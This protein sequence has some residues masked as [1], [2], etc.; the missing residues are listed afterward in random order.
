MQWFHLVK[1][2]VAMM[3]QTEVQASVLGHAPWEDLDTFTQYLN[4]LLC[5]MGAPDTYCKVIEQIK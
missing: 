3:T 2:T 4:F 1:T 5:K